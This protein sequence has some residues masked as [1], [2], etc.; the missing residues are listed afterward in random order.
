MRP[1]RSSLSGAGPNGGID[2]CTEKAGVSTCPALRGVKL[3]LDGVEHVLHPGDLVRTHGLSE[4]AAEKLLEV[5][6][7]HAR[8]F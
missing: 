1:L 8:G 7:S 2:V 6:A 4:E 3:P 5:V